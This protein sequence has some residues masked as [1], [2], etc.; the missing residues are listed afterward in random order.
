MDTL[1]GDAPVAILNRI[2]VAGHFPSSTLNPPP[3]QPGPYFDCPT[4][5][6]FDI[7]QIIMQAGR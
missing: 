6:F 1:N 7:R 4:R 3:P 5:C 2:G